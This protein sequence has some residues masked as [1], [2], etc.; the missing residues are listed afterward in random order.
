MRIAQALAGFTMGQADVLRKAMGKKDPKVMAKQR[1]A[2][3]RRREGA[4]HQREEGGQ[5]LRADR[6]L[7]RLR[8]QQVALDGLRAAGVPDGLSEGELPVALR[9]GAAHHRGAE[10][11][12]ACRLP[13]RRP[14]ARHPDAAA[15]HQRERAELHGGA[16]QG[17]PVR[18][19]GDQGT[20][21]RRGQR[22]HRR[23]RASSAGGFRR[24]TR[25]AKSIDLRIANKRV[26]EALV[27]SGACDSLMAVNAAGRT[28]A[29]GPRARLFAAIDAACEHGVRTQ[30]DKDLG[31][32]Q[33]FGGD[34]TGHARLPARR[35]CRPRPRGPR[36]SSC[37][38]RRT[39]SGCTGRAIRSIGMRMRSASTARSP[40][41]I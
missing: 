40:P 20:R 14:R 11:R 30:R 28:C 36:S 35:R 8:L 29:R 4:G 15:E 5:D 37:S 23:A 32:T 17:R 33:L 10:H 25:C 1:E 21:R 7:R 39:R 3:H 24:F 13:Q 12:Q 38:T 19:D 6:V 18:A 26:F 9:R 41:R 22:D 31:Q 16:G 34:E 2:V 27:K